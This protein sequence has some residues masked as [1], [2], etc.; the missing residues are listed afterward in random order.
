MSNGRSTARFR[1]AVSRH[2][3]SWITRLD[4]V[5]IKRLGFNSVRL[6][7][8]HWILDVGGERDPGMGN[9]GQPIPRKPAP[10]YEGERAWIRRARY[11]DADGKLVY[12]GNF[13]SEA[14]AA[15]AYNAAIKEAGLRRRVNPVDSDGRPV[16]KKRPDRR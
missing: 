3:R 12:V 13:V 9:G 14:A 1:S 5:Q 10:P 2:R 7:V 16:P 11:Y 4:L 6:P 15:L 8:G